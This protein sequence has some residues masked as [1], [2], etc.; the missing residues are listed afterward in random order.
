ML[1]VFTL[2]LNFV[3]AIICDS[4]CEVKEATNAAPGIL[5]EIQ[6]LMVDWFRHITGKLLYIMQNNN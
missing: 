6:G 1:L 3:L 5:E 4:F 2:L